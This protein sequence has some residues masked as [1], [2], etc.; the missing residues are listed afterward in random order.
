MCYRVSAGCVDFVDTGGRGK[1]ILK[2]FGDIIYGCPQRL[3]DCVAAFAIE[4]RFP[5][6][7]GTVFSRSTKCNF[8]CLDI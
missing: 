7:I 3:G 6:E 1:K 2:L 5:G 4:G 8:Q